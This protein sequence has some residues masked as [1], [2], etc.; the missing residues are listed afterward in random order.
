MLTGRNKL[1]L[2]VDRPIQTSV[3]LNFFLIRRYVPA[4]NSVIVNRVFPYGSLPTIKEFVPSQ[5]NILSY[6]GGS[7]ASG[8]EATG[9][10]TILEQ[11]GSFIEY[12]KPLL[13][14]DNTPTGILK[15]EFPVT[16]I[17]VTPDEIVRDLRDKKLIE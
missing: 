5:N 8:S 16:E 3:D 14:E 2:T 13:K 1:Q 6:D 4:P 10:T 7:G 12:I 17:D 15:P 9:S 11:S